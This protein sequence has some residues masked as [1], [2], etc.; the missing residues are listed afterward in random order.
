MKSLRE[1]QHI[2]VR[3]EFECAASAEGGVSE[4]SAVQSSAEEAGE[5]N[6]EIPLPTDPSPPPK[7]SP[8]SPLTGPWCLVD[9]NAHAVGRA[10]LYAPDPPPPR[11]RPHVQ[12]CSERTSG[13]FSI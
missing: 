8:P 9:P 6:E 13:V 1:P 12:P 2:G 10:G 5:S 7:I 11:P 4:A 3:E